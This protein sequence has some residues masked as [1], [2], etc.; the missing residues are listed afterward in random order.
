MQKQIRL[1]K[2]VAIQHGAPVDAAPPTHA[3]QAMDVTAGGEA[4]ASAA[5]TEDPGPVVDD[6]QSCTTV[7]SSASALLPSAKKWMTGPQ[8][9]SILQPKF[10]KAGKK[11]AVPSAATPNSHVSSTYGRRTRQPKEALSDCHS[12]VTFPSCTGGSPMSWS[13]P[14]VIRRVSEPPLHSNSCA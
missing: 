10:D 13:I 2:I 11:C 12:S 4:T 1:P 9:A 14:S 8:L 6:T 7:P 5:N 3:T